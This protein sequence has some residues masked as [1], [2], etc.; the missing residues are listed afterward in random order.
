[1]LVFASG[2]APTTLMGLFSAL[3]LNTPFGY[4]W[5]GPSRKLRC[6]AHL[7]D[8][9]PEVNY[10]RPSGD[11]TGGAPDE[12]NLAPRSLQALFTHVLLTFF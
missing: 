4:Y 2:S 6:V 5:V 11:E 10:F 7:E 1:M 8:E 12:R 3:S 9:W